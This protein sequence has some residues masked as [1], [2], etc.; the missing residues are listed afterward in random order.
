MPSGQDALPKLQVAMQLPQGRESHITPLCEPI[1]TA[2]ATGSDGGPN[3]AA[4][5]L[6]VAEAIAHE[7]SKRAARSIPHTRLQEMHKTF[8]YV[9]A[10]QESLTVCRT[11]DSA[12]DSQRREA[13]AI[14]P[15]S[16][17]LRGMGSQLF[18]RKLGTVL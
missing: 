17:Q 11:V 14:R 8:T 18:G 15:A 6:I 16:E 3:L 7:L 10:Q 12:Q 4:S 2:W 13:H 9:M 1:F 5:E